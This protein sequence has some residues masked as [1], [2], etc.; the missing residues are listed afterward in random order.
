MHVVLVLVL[1]V[2]RPTFN[3][4]LQD[5]VRVDIGVIFRIV[6][7]RDWFLVDLDTCPPAESLKSVLALI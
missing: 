6:H 3:S 4:L 1:P 2:D 5:I 7:L